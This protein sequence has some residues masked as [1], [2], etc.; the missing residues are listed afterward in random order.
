MP[1][2]RIADS[3]SAARVLFD[4][5]LHPHH[6]LGP[7]G[8]RLVIGVVVVASTALSLVFLVIGAWPVVGFFGL[9]VLLVW[10]AFRAND[11][12]RRVYERVRLTDAELTVQRVAW[13]RPDRRWS[14]QPYWLRVRMDDPPRHESQVTLSSHG[15]MVTVGAFLTPE[16]RLDFANALRDALRAWRRGP[17]A[18]A[19]P[20]PD[21][22]R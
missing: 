22:A 7:A 20:E 18:P 2:T 11:R 5:V 8:V 14:F 6:S 13:M 17:C 3:S 16:E 21:P 10:W 4:A 15:R 12:A 1:M 9:D 19:G